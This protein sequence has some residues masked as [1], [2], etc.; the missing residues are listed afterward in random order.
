MHW[1]DQWELHA[2]IER[3]DYRKMSLQELIEL[4]KQGLYGNYYS[5]WYVISEKTDALQASE[6]LFSVL[7]KS[8]LDQLYRYHSAAALIGILDIKELR[9]ADLCIENADLSPVED[10]LR[11]RG[12][13]TGQTPENEFSISYSKSLFEIQNPLRLKEP[14]LWSDPCCCTRMLHICL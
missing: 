5:I 10:V 9:P 4:I 11:E 14:G 1:K 3:E 2:G 12:L 8:N 13:I 7:K 6:V